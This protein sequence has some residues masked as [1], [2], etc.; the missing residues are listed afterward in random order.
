[1]KTKTIRLAVITGGKSFDVIHFHKLFQ[2][3]VG[4]DSFIQ[5]I[6]DFAAS[7]E[8]IRDSYDVVLFYFMMLDG[9]SDEGM[10][11]YCGQPKT[12][13]V[14]LGQ[15]GQGIVLL[16]H[17]LLAYPQWSIWGEMV[18]IQDRNLSSYQHDEK[19]RINVADQTH[20]IT[21]G[22]LDWAMIDETY[23]MANAVGH[24][25]ILLKVDHPQSMQT[26]A[27][28]HQY[29]NSRVFSLQLGHDQQSWTDPNFRTILTRGIAWCSKFNLPADFGN[30]SANK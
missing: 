9:P 29:Q 16:H 15:T 2:S 28:T 1:M 3:M 8:S 21:Q 27:W 24:N 17:A 22:L 12:A 5:H 11:G 4:I 26:L 18:G 7:P 6:D 13:L 20:P 10:P 23:L 19:L 25:R 30:S 14:R